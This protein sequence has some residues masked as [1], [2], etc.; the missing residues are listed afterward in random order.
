LAESALTIG[1]RTTIIGTA[2]WETAARYRLEARPAEGGEWE[3]I[4][5]VR[6]PVN[7]A[8]VGDVGYGGDGA[9]GV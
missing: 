9:R 3:L 1:E 6:R 5:V 4:S 7:T 2:D 8:P